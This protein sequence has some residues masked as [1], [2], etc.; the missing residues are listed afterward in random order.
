MSVPALAIHLLK[1]LARLVADS[2]AMDCSQGNLCNSV[3]RT[4][5]GINPTDGGLTSAPGMFGGSRSII[6][7]VSHGSS[8]DGPM[9]QL[10]ALCDT[11]SAAA[12]SALG[13]RQLISVFNPD[14]GM[15]SHHDDSN[16][17]SVQ[18]MEV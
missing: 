14:I 3:A 11:V 4:A 15:Q 7:H 8:N 18:L 13:K 9:Q 12:T 2:C 1:C 6:R 10:S 17:T 5:L 16:D